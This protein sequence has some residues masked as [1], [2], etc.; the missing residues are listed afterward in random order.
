M[1]NKL[2][3]LIT[4]PKQNSLELSRFINESEKPF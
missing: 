2:Q 3:Q 1:Q 4:L